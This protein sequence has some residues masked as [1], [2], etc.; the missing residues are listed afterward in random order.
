MVISFP[1]FMGFG[2]LFF[3]SLETLVVSHSSDAFLWEKRDA[4]WWTSGQSLAAATPS[5]F[6]SKQTLSLSL[7]PSLPFAASVFQTLFPD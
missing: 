6:L 2:R 5:P 7:S 3:L 4:R 1:F